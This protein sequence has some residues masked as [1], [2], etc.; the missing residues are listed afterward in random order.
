MADDEAEQ[1]KR[2]KKTKVPME[3]PRFA[4]A[5][6]PIPG[7]DNVE[8]IKKPN[9]I[10][11]QIGTFQPVGSY[12]TDNFR[13]LK[14]VSMIQYCYFCQLFVF[15][16][17]ILYIQGFCFLYLKVRLILVYCQSYVQDNLITK[18]NVSGKV[19]SMKKGGVPQVGQLKKLKILGDNVKVINPF[20]SITYFFAIVC[21]QI[22][23]YYLFIKYF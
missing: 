21:R 9:K 14:E 1:K 23:Y 7:I 12:M 3:K 4:P 16:T 18:R 20:Y 22:Y 2:K 19:K 15:C 11:K 17:C 13:D 8:R 6:Q 5:I 10:A